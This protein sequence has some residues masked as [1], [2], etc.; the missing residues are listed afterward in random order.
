MFLFTKAK[1]LYTQKRHAAALAVFQQLARTR[2]RSAPGS[3]T[4]DEVQYFIALCQSKL[5]NKTAAASIW[6]TLARDPLSYYGQRA[7]EKLGRERVL[8]SGPACLSNAISKTIEANVANMRHPLRGEMD[9]MAD[10]ASELVFLRLWDEAAF[11]MTA[12]E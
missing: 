12:R 9:P 4:A 7:A 5:G 11:W 3:A 1:V 2:L 10:A 6:R 8:N